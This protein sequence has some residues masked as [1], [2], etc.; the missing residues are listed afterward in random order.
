MTR[1]DRPTATMALLRAAAAGDPPVALAEEGVGPGGSDGG[2]AEDAGQVGV[3][4]AGGAVAFLLPGGFLDA[5]RVL[6]P[7]DQ[8]A[9]GGEPGHVQADLGDD[10]R[11][12]RRGRC[13]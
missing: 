2:L 4:V 3:A 6:R 13:R 12:A 9:G 5:W 7:G 8:V 11:G 10:D 1:M